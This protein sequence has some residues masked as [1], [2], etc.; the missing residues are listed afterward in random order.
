MD[1]L[2]SDRKKKSALDYFEDFGDQFFIDRDENIKE[3]VESHE[4]KFESEFGAEIKKAR[5]KGNYAKRLGSGKKSEIVHR[6]RQIIDGSQ[7]AKL[8][9]VID[10][11]KE[12]SQSRNKYPDKIFLM[13]DKLDQDWID[14]AVKFRLIGSLISVVPTFRGIENLKLMVSLLDD[15]LERSLNETKRVASQR[16]K[17]E[18]YITRIRW[19]KDC[20]Y[21][22]INER[23]KY[24]FKRQYTSQ[25]VGFKDIFPS[26]VDGKDSF[27]YIRERTQMRPRDLLSFVNECF[28][29]SEKHT[30]SVRAIKRAER[31]YARLRHHAICE[32]W[33]SIYPSIETLIEFANK[34]IVGR[35]FKNI[36]VKDVVQD[37]A[38]DLAAMGNSDHDAICQEAEGLIDDM[39]PKKVESFARS[40][41]E[42]LY[43]AGVVGVKIE[44]GEPFEFSDVSDPLI[45]RSMIDM[46]TRFQLHKMFFRKFRV[47]ESGKQ[48]ASSN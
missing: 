13:I 18:D 48:P 22:F 1:A 36:A 45:D 35:K 39:T 46:N 40:V 2:R 14:D 33:E 8:G 19:S 17:H 16:E 4:R 6:T 37:L 3:L 32:D 29:A 9:K 43:R 10:I 41:I 21:G 25:E 34:S 12:E 20:L 7:L 15:I 5:A 44:H 38:L 24:T 23:I 47:H 31:E 26:S 27:E 30:I 28:K 42:A 11:L